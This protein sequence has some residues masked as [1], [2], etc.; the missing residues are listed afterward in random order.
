MRTCQLCNLLRRGGPSHGGSQ[1]EGEAPVELML[2]LR[3][4]CE[5]G[6][7]GSRYLLDGN[8]LG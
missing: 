3:W 4:V 7:N 5:E 1:I 6:I 2:A 8:M